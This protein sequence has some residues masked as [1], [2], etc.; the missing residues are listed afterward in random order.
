MPILCV[1]WRTQNENW[2]Q[3]LERSNYPIL[4]G[5]YC[6]YDPS[7]LHVSGLSSP[8]HWAFIN[9]IYYLC[10][11]VSK[12]RQQLYSGWK[13][14]KIGNKFLGFPKRTQLLTDLF[15]VISNL[16]K[17]KFDFSHDSVLI[18]T[19]SNTLRSFS[20]EKVRLR[21][22]ILWLTTVKQRNKHHWSVRYCPNV[23]FG[24]H[25]MRNDIFLP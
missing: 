5:V 16:E 10:P 23:W 13:V 20:D 14:M 21:P 15:S 8:H 19:R 6:L 2:S 12:W 3:L 7:L 17:H 22:V 24:C 18:L 11:V 1:W 9:C 4:L 25:E